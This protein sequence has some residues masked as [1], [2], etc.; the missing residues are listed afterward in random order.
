MLSAPFLSL[1][2]KAALLLETKHTRCRQT[3]FERKKKEEE[4]KKKNNMP[5]PSSAGNIEVM[6]RIGAQKE[7]GARLCVYPDPS[8]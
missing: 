4:K 6:V 2:K 7:G 1:F 8:N 5:P 3:K